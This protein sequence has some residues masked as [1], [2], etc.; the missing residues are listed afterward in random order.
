MTG[1]QI[2]KGQVWE[3]L[4]LYWEDGKLVASES[5]KVIGF[6]NTQ[7]PQRLR[8]DLESLRGVGYINMLALDLI[9]Q[10]RLARRQG[11]DAILS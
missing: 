5:Y 6:S 10:Y 2:S 11:H 9:L 4:H 3:S 7:E 1:I 8:V